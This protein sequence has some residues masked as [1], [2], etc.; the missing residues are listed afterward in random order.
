MSMPR[1]HGAANHWLLLR[2]GRRLRGGRGGAL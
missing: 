1:R 2:L